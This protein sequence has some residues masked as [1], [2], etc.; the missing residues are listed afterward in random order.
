MIDNKM[1]LID[2]T[3]TLSFHGLLQTH[4]LGSYLVSTGTKNS[5]NA[6][7]GM[8]LSYRA[9]NTL[10]L[11][12]SNQSVNAAQGNNPCLFS[13]PPKTH[14]YTVLAERRIIY[15]DPVR[16]AQQTHSSQLCKPVS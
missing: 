13:D 6:G 11:T 4:K 12:Y 5:R 10:P 3:K 9:V 16:T 8:H 14:K 2:S 15:K 7:H 1:C